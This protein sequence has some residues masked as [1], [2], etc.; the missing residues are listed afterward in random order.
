MASETTKQEVQ[1]QLTSRADTSGFSQFEGASDRLV[2][3]KNRQAQ[4]NALLVDSERRVR[5]NLIDTVS[6]FANA[7]DS[8][9][10]L[11][12][13]VTHLSEVFNIGFAGAVIAGVGAAL[14]SAFD[15]GEEALKSM[16]EELDRQLESAGDLLEE[17]Q[18]IKQTAERREGKALGKEEKEDQA[19]NAQLQNPGFFATVA[20]GAEKLFGLGSGA[21]NFAA[22]RQKEESLRQTILESAGALAAKNEEIKLNSGQV[23]GFSD[24]KPEE[25]LSQAAFRSLVENADIDDEIK[26]KRAKDAQEAAART[27][28]TEEEADR[29]AEEEKARQAREDGRDERAQAS[30]RRVTGYKVSLH[31]Y[32]GAQRQEGGGGRAYSTIIVDP[33]VTEARKTNQLL[34]EINGN[35]KANTAAAKA[36]PLLA[37]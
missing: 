3:S 18:G 36:P 6:S 14:V 1:V 35:L 16:G 33:V 37:A 22:D 28:R 5:T 2:A 26:K 34:A 30:E 19:K 24:R 32:A 9:Q 23:K 21:T 11:A 12:G 20:I 15:K 13:A 8:T 10:A 27:A 17:I 25:N 7:K 4:A 29:K 31:D